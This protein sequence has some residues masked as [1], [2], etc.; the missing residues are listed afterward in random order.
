MGKKTISIEINKTLG[1]NPVH[2]FKIQLQCITDYYLHISHSAK[3]LLI[4]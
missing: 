2:L 1:K 3:A 4:N